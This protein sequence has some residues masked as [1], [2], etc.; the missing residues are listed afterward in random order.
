MMMQAVKLGFSNFGCSFLFPY[1][2]ICVIEA[3]DF[4]ISSKDIPDFDALL[5]GGAS[6]L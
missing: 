2:N 3:K 1:W 5:G 6:L 4:T